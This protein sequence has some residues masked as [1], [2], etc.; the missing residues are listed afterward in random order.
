[1]EIMTEQLLQASPLEHPAVRAWAKLNPGEGPPTEVRRLQKKQK[2]QVYRLMRARPEGTAIIAK[3]SSLIRIRSERAVYEKVL[4]ALP[5]CSVRYLGSIEEPDEGYGWL[6]LEDAGDEAYSPLRAECRVLAGRWLAC[7]HSSAASL[8]SAVP[9]PDRGPEYYFEHLQS[10]R[11]TILGNRAHPGLTGED[12]VVLKTV[13]RQMEVVAAHWSEVREVCRQ[14]PRTFI[15]GDF[16]PKNMRVRSG[17]A[18]TAL[19]PFDWG[20][21]G[22]GI[23]AADLVQ[24]SRSS[25]GWSGLDLRAYWAS[26]DLAAYCD[27]LREAGWRLGVPDARTLAVVGKFFRCLVCI[28][29][30]AQSFATAWV[31]DAARKMR[32]YSTEMADALRATGWK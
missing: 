30:E 27:V 18:G 24:A 23:P 21:A 12:V 9:L 20:S 31:E 15:H 22:W 11:A 10:G 5:V 1:M 7:L 2:G 32:L 26:P 6:F 29:L 19:V 28:D 17:T 14:A 25:P 3:R 13:I 8:A 4:C 16:A